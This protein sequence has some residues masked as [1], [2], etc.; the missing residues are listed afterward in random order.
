M[1]STRLDS[2][3]LSARSAVCSAVGIVV[4]TSESVSIADAV[5]V[6]VLPEP[7]VSIEP[8]SA[9]VPEGSKD[10]VRIVITLTFP[11]VTWIVL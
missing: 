6:T 5:P 11:L 7:R 4:Y 1:A 2:H 9:A 10:P 8:V 3:C